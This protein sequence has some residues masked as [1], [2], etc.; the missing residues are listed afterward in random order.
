[1]Q[2]EAPVVPV[3]IRNTDWMMGKRTGVAYPGTIE[4]VLFPPIET[5]TED[6]PK[7]LMELLIEA[8]GAIAS[9]L[10]KEELT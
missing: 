5:K 3:A 6:G 9:E 7:D 4:I 2:T 8:R 1:L 10:A